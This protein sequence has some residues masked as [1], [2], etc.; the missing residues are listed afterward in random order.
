MPCL[1]LWCKGELPRWTEPVIGLGAMVGLVSVTNTFLH[2][3]TP[4]RLSLIRTGAGW[5]LGGLI[6]LA[7]LGLVRLGRR[8]LWRT[9]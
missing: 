7:L 1:V 6:G 3:C 9:S 5:L 4:L 2:L 8:L